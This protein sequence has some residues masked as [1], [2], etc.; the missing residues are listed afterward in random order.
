MFYDLTYNVKERIITTLRMCFNLG[1]D[2]SH[3]NI[4]DKMPR[5][6]KKL[7][8]IVVKNASTPFERAGVDDYI[9]EVVTATGEI[10]E[11]FKRGTSIKSVK[12]Q[13]N[14]LLYCPT[15]PEV[16]RIDILE[17]NQIS[18][19]RQNTR[20]RFGPIPVIPGS[21]ITNLIFDVEIELDD[22]LVPGDFSTILLI[23]IG[24]PTHKLYGGLF[25]MELSL[26]V[27]AG[28]TTELEQIVDSAAIYLWVAKKA[29]LEREHNILI[30]TM[31]QTGEQEIPEYKDYIYTAG[32]DISLRSQW[33]WRVPVDHITG[34]DF[35]HRDTITCDG[36]P[37]SL[38]D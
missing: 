33:A 12:I 7:P 11:T 15:R 34:I 29:D 18:V 38:I 2:F 30:K 21:K 16:F 9:K 25:E 6:L 32:I 36:I 35:V 26:N 10:K 5:D 27:M 17:D 20:R 31:R 8:A 4:T 24:G 37:I 22:I 23:P 1:G 19:F 13:E 14:H 28:S 3:I